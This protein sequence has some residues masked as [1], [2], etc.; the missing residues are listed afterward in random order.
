MHVPRYS[1]AERDRRWAL[2]RKLM[3][4]E[5]VEALIAC[6]E[7]ECAGGVAFAP[8]AYFSNDRPGSVVIFCRDAD[9][10]Q[11][12]WPDRTG[13][14]APGGPSDHR[15]RD[16]RPSDQAWIDLARVRLGRDRPGTGAAAVAEVLREHRLERVAVGV[17]GTGIAAPLQ[18]NSGLWRDVLAG[19]PGVTLRPVGQRFL[20]A[21][22]RLS[23]EELAVLR[24]C[25]AAGDRMARAMLET[26]APG[27]TEAEVCAAGAA[28]ALRLGCQAPLPMPLWSGPGLAV[29]GAP[30]WW[31][32]PGPPRVLSEGDVLLAGPACRL[33]PLETRHQLAIAIGDPHPDTETAA[34]IARASYE[35]GLRAAR[36]GNTVGDL[37]EA[38]LTPFKVSGAHSI[39]PLLHAL[40]PL[41]SVGGSG[42][43]AGLPADLPLAT[44]MSW[45]LGPS[46]VVCGRAVTL[47]GTVVI[48][49]GGPVE[50]NPFTAQ[51]LRVG[52]SAIGR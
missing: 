45:A 18:L 12:A 40:T 43:V 52:A 6:G 39:H 2:A 28:A 25:T 30:D 9:P 22:S 20:F 48:G 4:A 16:H 29:W 27:V 10:V 21:A 14:T 23:A 49:E 35:A 50:F 19:L 33:G 1:L 32:R 3:A 42:P 24:Y 37:T 17:L 31:Y 7:P 5:G 51:L 15:P 47:G 38:M 11:L 36:V 26:A 44:G 8:D 13:Q 34:V 46:A 41:G